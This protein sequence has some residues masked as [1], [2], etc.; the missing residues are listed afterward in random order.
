MSG[1]PKEAL[2]VN[3]GETVILDTSQVR[4]RRRSG[5]T[6][7][8]FRQPGWEETNAFRQN[9]AKKTP[10]VSWRESRGVLSSAPSQTYL[11]DTLEIREG[12]TLRATGTEPLVLNVAKFAIIAGTID[13]NG[14]VGAGASHSKQSPW[15]G[16]SLGA[17]PIFNYFYMHLLEVTHGR[18][19]WL[20]GL[21][22]RRLVGTASRTRAEGAAGPAVARSRLRRRRLP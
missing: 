17:P 5:G 13:L 8:I 15:P 16:D 6:A 21:C 11:L 18:P 1:L 7:S 4:G 3:D 14:A 2:T 20:T 10:R 19:P 9:D 12:G 22:R